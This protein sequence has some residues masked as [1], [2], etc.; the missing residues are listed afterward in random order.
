MLLDTLE[1]I[2]SGGV[3]CGQGRKDGTKEGIPLWFTRVAAYRDWI[4]CISDGI[5]EGMTKRTIE[6]RC[7]WNFAARGDQYPPKNLMDFS[8]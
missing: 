5:I 7:D 2:I 1:A 4:N 3:T 6:R 8:S